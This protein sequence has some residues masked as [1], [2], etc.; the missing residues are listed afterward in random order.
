ME[1]LLSRA[2]NRKKAEKQKRFS[3][4]KSGAAIL[5]PAPFFSRTH[6]SPKSTLQNIMFF[7]HVQTA[8]LLLSFSNFHFPGTP[9]PAVFSLQF[10]AEALGKPEA[11][12]K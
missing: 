4:I 6:F 11:F 3:S 2:R 5:S 1:Y 7:R 8:R 10:S 9:E 12:Q